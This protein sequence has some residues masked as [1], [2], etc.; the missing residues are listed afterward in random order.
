MG[1]GNPQQEAAT[2]AASNNALLA[3]RALGLATP[4]LK[5]DLSYAQGALSTGE[6]GYVKQ[7]YNAFLSNLSAQATESSDAD[8]RAALKGKSGLQYLGALGSQ[9]GQ[10]A[11]REA[12][13]LS[14]GQ[15]SEGQAMF[16]QTQNLL[17]VMSGQAIGGLNQSA[18]F[19]AQQAQAIAGMQKY[20]ST[21]AT[22]MG[23]LSAAGSVYGAY[24]NAELRNAMMN[25]YGGG[26]GATPSMGGGG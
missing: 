13:A 15:L 19:S 24:Q 21:T 1:G 16:S 5:G 14:E 11:G 8:L 9:S 17:G 2:E 3:S 7:G 25:Y 23:T 20:N 4:I 26:L 6:P 12:A 22:I 18:G 10:G